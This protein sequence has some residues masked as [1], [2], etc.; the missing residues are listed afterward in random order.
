MHL[1]NRNFLTTEEVYQDLFHKIETLVY[2]PGVRISENDLCETYGVSRH[3]V[4]NAITQLKAQGLITVYPQRGTYVSLIDMKLVED[5]LYVREA[6]EQEA[7]YRVI[8]L[9]DTTELIDHLDANITE[10][11]KIISHEI[12]VDDFN[13]AD[14][15]FHRNLLNAVGKGN[16]LDLLKEE[17]VHVKRWKN[18]ELRDEK[19][20][21][22][23][24]RDHQGIVDAIKKRSP[25]DGR[26]ALH[27]HLDTVTNLRDVFTT[28]NPEY[29]IRP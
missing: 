20:Y 23:I 6:V 26:N 10:Q 3:I 5:I 14:T 28:A 24:I 25:L 17:Y 13:T 11:K 19:R 21:E 15:A 12:T 9:S 2:M 7:L 27:Q 4:R 22:Q 29:F 1:V 16:V 8:D 18:F